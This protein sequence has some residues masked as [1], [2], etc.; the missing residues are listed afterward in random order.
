MD[1]GAVHVA[2]ALGLPVVDV[3][4]RAGAEHVVPRWKPWQV[5]HEVVLRGRGDDHA[6][7]S[8]VRDEIVTRARA[9]RDSLHAG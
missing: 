2:A 1:T 4:P 7:T 3:F 6:E 9:L 8:R 5:A